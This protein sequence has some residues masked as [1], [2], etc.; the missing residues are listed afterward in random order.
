ML[1]GIANIG[2]GAAAERLGPLLFCDRY[3]TAERLAHR[4]F[5]AA[6][7]AD[8]R[9][10]NTVQF[11]VPPGKAATRGDRKGAID[12]AARLRNL[13]KPQQRLSLEAQVGG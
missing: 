13:V 11:G 12:G 6:F 8:H 5:A 1:S 2:D 9:G 7:G 4:R 10:V 3:G